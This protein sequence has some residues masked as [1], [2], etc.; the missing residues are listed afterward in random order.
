MIKKIFIPENSTKT[1][2]TNNTTPTQRP[3]KAVELGQYILDKLKI[4]NSAENTRFLNQKGEWVEA[5][6]DFNNLPFFQNNQDAIDALGLNQLY[7]TSSNGSFVIG[8]AQTGISSFSAGKSTIGFTPDGSGGFDIEFKIAPDSSQLPSGETITDY[9]YSVATYV[10]G[11]EIA[12][13]DGNETGDLSLNVTPTITT[14][15]VL[16]QTYNV[17]DGSIF[18]IAST[19]K[20]DASGNILG[21]I[22]NKGLEVTG[23]NVVN[24]TYTADI[25]I[26]GVSED[27]IIA[28]GDASGNSTQLSNQLTDT[29]TLPPNTVGI[30]AYTTLDPTFWSDLPPSIIATPS[31]L[32][33][34]TLVTII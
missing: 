3:N 14:D 18:A 4:S 13:V 2:S 29:I 11:V 6:V 9:D 32:N 27:I 28:A 1:I 26:S 8:W 34:I 21:Y 10:G 20:V 25:T 12:I 23:I 22:I 24:V 7:L 31:G 33:G 16:I 19:Y 5:S 17:S 15:Y 30:A